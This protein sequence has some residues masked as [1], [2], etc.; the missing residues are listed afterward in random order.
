[1]VNFFPWKEVNGRKK[2]EE[3]K[4]SN[5]R[6]RREKR[7]QRGTRISRSGEINRG[8]GRVYRIKATQCARTRRNSS[9]FRQAAGSCAAWLRSV[10][11][12]LPAYQWTRPRA[13][14]SRSTASPSLS[15]SLA[16]SLPAAQGRL[17]PARLQKIDFTNANRHQRCADSAR[18]KWTAL[19][20]HPRFDASLSLCKRGKIV[21]NL[22]G[23]V[24]GDFVISYIAWRR[25]NN[26]V[27]LFFSRIE[28][29]RYIR[30]LND[31]VISLGSKL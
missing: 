30:Y 10:T 3:G 7:G 26:G 22:N 16:L 1:M 14:C 6:L 24:Y 23:G 5:K 12:R 21:Q 17:I 9:G 31:E 8:A 2:K 20:A 11:H 15:L 4:K 19:G 13:T 28:K 27:Y 29:S 18:R 25:E